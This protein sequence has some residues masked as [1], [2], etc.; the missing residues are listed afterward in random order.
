MVVSINGGI[1]IAGWV[2]REHPIKMDDNY[3]YPRFRTPPNGI[4]LLKR[5][6][7]LDKLRRILLSCQ[8]LSLNSWQEKDKYSHCKKL[9]DFGVL[10]FQRNQVCVAEVF[11]LQ[12]KIWFL[13][14]FPG[15]LAEVWCKR[16]LMQLWLKFAVNMTASIPLQMLLSVVWNWW[17]KLNSN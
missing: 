10:D 11:F 14:D 1:P 17:N 9:W 6:T 4:N 2:L 3:G 15:C 8:C 13:Y 16:C 7:V 5:R 12:I